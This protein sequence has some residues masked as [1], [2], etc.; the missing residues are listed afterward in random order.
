MEDF[1]QTLKTR[2]PP[3]ICPCGGE[4]PGG[5]MLN[6][7]FPQTRKRANRL[8]VSRNPKKG[9]GQVSTAPESRSG[10]GSTGGP[11]MQLS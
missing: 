5:S 8:Q 11:G 9:C 10:L 6:F 4:T 3:Y 1:A 7:F 2:K